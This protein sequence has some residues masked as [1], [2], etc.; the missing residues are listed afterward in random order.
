[1]GSDRCVKTVT[2]CRWCGQPAGSVPLC[3]GPCF[4]IAL[5]C[6]WFEPAK[7][8]ARG[9]SQLVAEAQ[10]AQEI[11]TMANGDFPNSGIL[12]KND[13]KR[14]GSHDPEYQGT[15]DITCDCGQR[16][17]RKLAGWLKTGRNGKFLALSLKPRPAR[18]AQASATAGDD[19]AW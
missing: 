17:T 14:E 3:S 2:Q 1:M 7:L 12:F 11:E 18:G 4:R 8:Y 19:I 9:N 10:A 15:V 16:F 5:W 6:G 13:R